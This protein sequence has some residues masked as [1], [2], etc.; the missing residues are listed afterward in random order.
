MNL[1][2]LN[3]N[4]KVVKEDITENLVDIYIKQ[5]NGRKCITLIEGLKND[6]DLL[7]S[8]S[9][10]LRKIMGCSCSVNLNEETGSYQLKLSG[11]D[12]QNI[13]KYLI[14]NLNIKV[15]NIKVHGE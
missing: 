6:K 5:R 10:D 12:I 3:T 7:K 15:E 14:D 4:T 11:K 1:D 9:K 13:C 8:Y 2:D